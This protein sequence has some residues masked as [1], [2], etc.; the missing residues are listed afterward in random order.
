M[1][2]FIMTLVLVVTFAAA[3]AG[4]YSHAA[5][6]CGTLSVRPAII[7]ISETSDG[8][9]CVLI[10]IGRDGNIDINMTLHRTFVSDGAVMSELMLLSREVY[11]LEKWIWNY[12]F[13]ALL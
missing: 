1:K 10:D 3:W 11:S 4:Y 7:D 9:T 5:I 12:W 13:N 8:Y 6:A 2:R